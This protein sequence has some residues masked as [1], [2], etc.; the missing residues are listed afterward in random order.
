MTRSPTLTATTELSPAAAQQQLIEMW[1]HGKS[2]R[3][4]Q[5]YR[6]AAVQFLEF[7]GKPLHLVTVAKVQAF[8]AQL[9]QRDI[10]ANTQRNIIA[11]NVLDLWKRFVSQHSYTHKQDIGLVL[12]PC[13]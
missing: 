8:A 9:Q 10:S 2:P 7:I 6:Q 12:K 4:V 11:G 1:V 13:W 5:S 3:T